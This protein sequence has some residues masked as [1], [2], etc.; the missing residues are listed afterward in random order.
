MSDPVDNEE[1]RELAWIK[2]YMDIAGA[3]ETEA[4]GVFMYMGCGKT[5]S[6]NG[7]ASFDSGTEVHHS[8]END[9]ETLSLMR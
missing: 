6:G 4:R 9:V 1:R 7:S 5:P 3:S 2:A 8:S